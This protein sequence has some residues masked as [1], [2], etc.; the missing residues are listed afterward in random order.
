MKSSKSLEEEGL[1]GI[2]GES[3]TLNGLGG[4]WGAMLD[5]LGGVVEASLSVLT[6]ENSVS[7]M[8]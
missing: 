8:I 2:G 4:T 5:L 3:Q 7:L 1:L 6:L